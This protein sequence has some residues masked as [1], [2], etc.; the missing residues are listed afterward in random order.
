[1]FVILIPVSLIK[2]KQ[3]LSIFIIPGDIT[4]GKPSEG[5]PV[6]RQ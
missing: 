4:M 2:R 6:L 1:M 5:H 3:N